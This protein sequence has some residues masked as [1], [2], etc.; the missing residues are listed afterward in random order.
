[1]ARSAWTVA[2]FLAVSLTCSAARGDEEFVGPFPSWKNVKT[3]Y[4]AVGDGKADDTAAIQR[5]LDDLQKHKDSVVLYFP[6]GA[7]RITDT[8]KTV[9]K[10]HTECM[11]VTVVGEDPATTTLR[12]DGKAGGLM[13]Q[14]DAWYSRIGRLTL[15]GAGR[16][17]VALAYGGGFS[18][19]NETA[20]MVFQDVGDGM[21]MATGNNGQAENEVLRCRFL[22]CSGAGLRTNNFNSLDIW[23]WYCRFEDCGW[24]LYNGAGNFHAYQCVFLRSRKMDVGAANLMV[25]S[26]INNFSMGSKCFMDWAGGHTW[27]S[28]TSITGNRII[29]PTG[30]FAIR[31]GNAGPYLLADNVIK[32]RAGAAGPVVHMTWGDQALV[33]NTYT[34]ANPVKE[35]GR[36]RRVAEK[37]VE[38]ATISAEPPAL[39][40]APPNRKRQVFEVAAG[41]DAAAIQAAIDK[42]VPLKGKRPVVHLPVGTYKIGQTLVIPAGADV[43]LVGDGGAETATVLQW[44]AKAGGPVLKLEGPSRATVRDLSVSAGAAGGILVEGCDQPG[45]RIFADQLNVPGGGGKSKA[46]LL[47]NGVEQADVLLRCLQGG[48]NSEKWV[49]VVGGPNQKAGKP[50]P[51]QTAIYAGATGSTDAQY[52][53]ADGGRLVVRSVYHEMSGAAPQGILLND[54][55]MLS[56]DATRFSYKTSADVP[57]VAVDGFRGDFALLTGL[58]LPVDSKHTA[59][60]EIKGDGSRSNVLVM[61]NTF[62]V[63]ELGVTAD[64]VFR[65][66]ARPPA[67]A[68]MLNCNMNSGTKGATKNGF[69]Y[70]ED[71]GQVDDEFL[72][73]MLR[74]LRESRIWLPGPTPEGVTDVRFYRVICSSGKDA[75][76]VEFRGAR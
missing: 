29:E 52:A 27:G 13:F 58:L 67:R 18:T 17:G 4:G 64:K 33:G 46:G 10:A 12:W 42:A 70:L 54:S 14:Y 63:N 45:G 23:A 38:A 25:F 53:I 24:G 50:T 66:E 35:N 47:V 48:S 62:W 11:G 20:D 61:D 3:D 22:R 31:L 21:A 7:Y 56:V 59:R 75:V 37:I 26:F 16:A 40:P 44:T 71:R 5:G 43:Q 8:V 69:D 34:V 32:S 60:I 15:D 74:P 28:A 6:A 19:Y 65:N 30:D 36:F 51:G 76:G 72:L 2:V 1:M 57:L 39:P 49:K 73:R 9:R 55:G 41:A 68:A